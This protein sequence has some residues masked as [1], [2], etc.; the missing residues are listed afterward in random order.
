VFEVLPL[1]SDILLI[2]LHPLLENMLQTIDHFI[3]FASRAPFFVV[4]KAQKSHG[5][6]IWTVWRMF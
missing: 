1:A 6:E 5:G 4:G 2:T 3:I